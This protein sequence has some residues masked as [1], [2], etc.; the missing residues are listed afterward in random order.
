MRRNIRD[1][2]G[3]SLK[4]LKKPEEGRALTTREC[5]LLRSAVLEARRRRLCRSWLKG[6]GPWWLLALR[7]FFSGSVSLPP[8]R[9]SRLSWNFPT[10]WRHR[11][12]DLTSGSLFARR[13]RVST[14]PFHSFDQ[15]RGHRAPQSLQR[16][17]FIDGNTG[18]QL[19]VPLHSVASDSGLPNAG[20]FGRAFTE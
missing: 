1:R 20:P 18:T 10:P 8:D 2:P 3:L 16:A 19:D 13:L 12:P 5:S 11:S 9:P 17:L 4:C 6:C 14:G 15:C 7:R